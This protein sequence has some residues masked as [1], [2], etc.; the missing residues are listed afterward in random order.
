MNHDDRSEDITSI[1]ADRWG[2]VF[3]LGGLAGLPFRGKTGWDAFSS[4]VPLNGNICILFAPHVGIDKDGTIGKVTREGSN[5]ASDA[6]RACI[7]AYNA[8]VFEPIQ[9]N[10][11]NEYMHN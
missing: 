8:I 9:S 5:R 2:E 11:Q 1:F 4:Q 7:S 6:C 3:P 10:F